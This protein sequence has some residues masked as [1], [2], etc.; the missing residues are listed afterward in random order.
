MVAYAKLLV[1]KLILHNANSNH[2]IITRSVL[3]YTVC[4]TVFLLFNHEL[5]IQCYSYSLLYWSLIILCSKLTTTA[6]K[7]EEDEMMMVGDDGADG[8]TLNN[9]IR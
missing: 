2:F 8:R 7:P 6:H 1:F 9:T 5:F 4:I 3:T